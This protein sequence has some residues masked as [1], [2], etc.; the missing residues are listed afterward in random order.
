M[1]FWRRK[2]LK[3][4]T[5]PQGPSRRRIVDG[6]MGDVLGRHRQLPEPLRSLLHVANE[7]NEALRRENAGLVSALRQAKG[8]LATVTTYKA[9][10]DEAE[11]QCR[12][13]TA[14]NTTLAKDIFTF[15]DALWKLDQAVERALLSD[16][17]EDC[18]LHQLDVTRGQIWATFNVVSDELK[19]RDR[20]HR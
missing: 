16:V 9:R 19:R 6:L 14:H 15:A 11:E 18:D 17:K 12:Q 1:R 20:E 7:E 10:L 3:L 2:P 8:T 13:L 5:D 4:N